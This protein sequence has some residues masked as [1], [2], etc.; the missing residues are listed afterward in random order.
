MGK[1][2]P[3]AAMILSKSPHQYFPRNIDFVAWERHFAGVRNTLREDLK[4]LELYNNT[5]QT[6]DDIQKDSVKKLE[7]LFG[8]KWIPVGSQHLPGIQ[9]SVNPFLEYAKKR[10]YPVYCY[11]ITEKK[12]VETDGTKEDIERIVYS[13]EN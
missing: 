4:P 5:P 7:E 1:E 3:K 8:V 6:W 10:D 12:L 13:F 11:E 9:Y 2:P